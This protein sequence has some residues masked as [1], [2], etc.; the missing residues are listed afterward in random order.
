MKSRAF[1]IPLIE[2]NSAVVPEDSSMSVDIGDGDAGF[3][4]YSCRVCR[5]QQLMQSEIPPEIYIC[6][7]CIRRFNNGSDAEMQRLVSQPVIEVVQSAKILLR[8]SASDIDHLLKRSVPSRR[9]FLRYVLEIS[10]QLSDKGIDVAMIE[11]PKN[12]AT[13]ITKHTVTPVSAILDTENVMGNPESPTTEKVLTGVDDL[14]KENLIRSSYDRINE[15]LGQLIT[16]LTD[17]GFKKGSPEQETIVTDDESTVSVAPEE[18]LSTLPHSDVYKPKPDENNP[19]N[20]EELSNSSR[21][22]DYN[23]NEKYRC[24]ACHHVK[25]FVETLRPP[26]FAVDFPMFV[27]PACLE[28]ENW[29]QLKRLIQKKDPHA[30]F[31]LRV[32][33]SHAIQIPKDDTP[34]GFELTSFFERSM[35]KNIR[36]E[37]LKIFDLWV[38]DSNIDVWNPDND[39]DS[40][41]S[42]DPPY[43][44][45]SSRGSTQRQC[46]VCREAEMPADI[47]L[48]PLS[49]VCPDCMWIDD[50]KPH[51]I[52]NLTFEAFISMAIRR[53]RLRESYQKCLDHRDKMD[54]GLRE[55]RIDQRWIQFWS[56]EI[57]RYE[58]WIRTNAISPLELRHYEE[59][60]RK[61]G[62][63]NGESLAKWF[64]NP[65]DNYGCESPL[66]IE[67]QRPDFNDNDR[68][69]KYDNDNESEDDRSTHSRDPPGNG[70]DFIKHCTKCRTVLAAF[71]VR[72]TS[73]HY[74]CKKCIWIDPDSTD[75]STANMHPETLQVILGKRQELISQEFRSLPDD[76]DT[77]NIDKNRLNRICGRWKT[78]RRRE[79]DRYDAWLVFNE[80]DPKSLHHRRPSCPGF[81]LLPPDFSLFR[82]ETW[83]H[84]R[85]LHHEK[86]EIS[87]QMPKPPKKPKVYVSDDDGTDTQD[88]LSIS[89]D[90]HAIPQEEIEQEPEDEPNPAALT[91]HT[92]WSNQSSDLP[93]SK[94]RVRFGIPVKHKSLN[95]AEHVSSFIEGKFKQLFGFTEQTDEIQNFS[96]FY[97]RNWIIENEPLKELIRHLKCHPDGFDH[98]KIII[99]F[100]Y[101][102][103]PRGYVSFPFLPGHEFQEN[104]LQIRIYHIIN[105][106]VRSNLLRVEI[107]DRIE[108][109][110]RLRA[111]S[112]NYIELFLEEEDFSPML[113]TSQYYLRYVDYN[114]ADQC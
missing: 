100:G 30:I 83:P 8:M 13:N 97:E 35:Q 36:L 67:W 7:N 3:T 2:V 26:S 91:I 39:S 27:C 10:R 18:D 44:M 88:M 86:P 24:V 94:I 23:R 41:H 54:N 85:T 84:R 107:L 17:N 14:I 76:L 61:L 21:K 95:T 22:S 50:E 109:E 106:I 103:H 29:I 69:W 46:L 105:E 68:K 42:K 52:E 25:T 114:P 34:E 19:E 101:R 55:I 73:T 31:R 4:Q 9:R 37:R 112:R 16:F 5:M 57:T 15:E 66:S 74:F 32:D 78:Y 99:Y 70:P 51:E 28:T 1:D 60:H 102:H 38:R 59:V 72:M 71:H 6:Q 87:Q 47:D 104:Q 20:L 110:I 96:D 77:D 62:T 90:E 93:L 43:L 56:C 108:V 89:G 81:R 58:E 64:Q 79:V 65:D 40:N 113:I 11:I 48:P 82:P 75:K 92:F 49:Y 12:S 98:G 45:Q 33:F 80:I 111:R 53:K 63:Y